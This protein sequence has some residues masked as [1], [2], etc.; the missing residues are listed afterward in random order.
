MSTDAQIFPYQ[1]NKSLENQ[2]A[3]HELYNFLGNDDLITCR[4]NTQSFTSPKLQ[5]G[6]HPLAFGNWMIH[7]LHSSAGTSLLVFWRRDVGI[8]TRKEEVRY[9]ETLGEDDGLMN[10]E[11]GRLHERHYGRGR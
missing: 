7:L 1:K 9:K 8:A 11:D 5:I 6:S 2:F 3:S 4:A 10:K